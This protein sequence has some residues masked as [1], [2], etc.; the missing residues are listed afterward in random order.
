MINLLFQP[1]LGGLRVNI[2]T[3]CISCRKTHGRLPIHD[4]L[5]WDVISRYWS[6]PVLFRR[7]WVTLSANFRW[8]GMSP[9]TNVGIRKLVFLLPHSEDRMILSSFIWIG[10]QRVTDGQT[11]LPWLIQSSSLQAMQLCC[12]K[13]A[14][15]HILMKILATFITK[16]QI[17]IQENM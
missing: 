16:Y 3:L 17:S 14:S 4:N 9:P 15:H 1:Q 6:K 12:K 8:K 2:C 13:G 7:G 10:Y 5:T 11:W